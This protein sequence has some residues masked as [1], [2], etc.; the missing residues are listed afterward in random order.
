[1]YLKNPK[2]YFVLISGEYTSAPGW[3]KD[4]EYFTNTISL[5]S[6]EFY[7]VATVWNPFEE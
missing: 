3:I 1:L 6:E 5:A 2:A 4:A 7:K